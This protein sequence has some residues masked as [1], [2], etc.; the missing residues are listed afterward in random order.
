MLLNL[1]FFSNLINH[2]LLFTEPT[3]SRK[4]HDWNE[5]ERRR[6]KEKMRLDIE[7]E[8]MKS[9]TSP[10]KQETS[11]FKHVITEDR[12]G[13]NVLDGASIQKAKRLRP[14]NRRYKNLPLYDSRIKRKCIKKNNRNSRS[15]RS[16]TANEEALSRRVR[17]TVMINTD[18]T[19]MEPPLT[20]IT[21]CHSFEKGVC[22]S[23]ITKAA[24]VTS[25]KKP[26][27]SVKRLK[28]ISA[29]SLRS[30][31]P[32]SDSVFYSEADVMTIHSLIMVE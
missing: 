28:A 19:A 31:S 3:R 16:R 11:N 10:T 4:A 18:S 15:P 25:P 7:K 1:F 27:G 23:I 13:M 14:K 12:Q 30:V 29:E 24:G 8:N 26:N 20:K 5:E 17:N 32:G 22:E 6:R 9:L 21:V 2:L